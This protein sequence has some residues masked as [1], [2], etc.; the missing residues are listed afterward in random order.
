MPSVTLTNRQA[1]EYWFTPSNGDHWTCRCGKEIAQKKGTGYSNLISH[2][3]SFKGHNDPPGQW[4]KVVQE[5][6]D[7]VRGVREAAMGVNTSGMTLYRWL[8]WIVR[9][10]LPFSFCES[11]RTR[12]NTKLKP[13]ATNTLKKYM[14]ETV[15][16]IEKRIKEELPP[17]FAIVI[18]GWSE[19]T[20]H[21]YG[22]F[23]AFAD[24]TNKQLSI[25][26]GIQTPQDETNFTA[27][28]QVEVIADVLAVYDRDLTSV[29]LLVADN[30]AVNSATAN[31]LSVGFIGC[32][33]H[34]FNLGMKAILEGHETILSK[35]D[36]I[37]HECLTLK[38]VTNLPIPHL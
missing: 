29:M 6:V 24:K 36:K 30:A 38:T 33:S 3:N 32:A 31:L 10:N 1:A 26:L 27:E 35:V 7:R 12:E 20:R 25:L 9:D 5:E 8:D 19:G 15:E 23:A 18:D 16:A 34:R 21:Y 17:R 14:F 11:E 2:L 13:I 28:N 4:S 37:M 22:V